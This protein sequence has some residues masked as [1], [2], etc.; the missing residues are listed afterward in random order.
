MVVFYFTDEVTSRWLDSLI[1]N[2]E[3]AAYQ[4]WTLFLIFVS[5]LILIS[6]VVLLTHKKPEPVTGKIKSS[7]PKR[8]RNTKAGKDM[9]LNDAENGNGTGEGSAGYG[10]QESP[11]G[12]RDVLWTVGNAS[13]DDDDALEDDDD[14]DHHQHPLHQTLPTGRVGGMSKNDMAPLHG[15]RSKIGEQTRLVGDDDEL[16]L[17][18]LSSRQ[19]R[20]SRRSMDPF[21][22]DEQE[23][24]NDYIKVSGSRKQQ[25]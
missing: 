9:T 15:A 7:A 12:E 24:L 11:D 25:R 21:R 22:D 13:D 8:K 1:F 4:S 23:A 2:D 16:E 19:E 18:A 5:I 6:G 17:G 10:D 14:V 3:V 20:D